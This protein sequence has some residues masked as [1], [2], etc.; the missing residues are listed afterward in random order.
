MKVAIGTIRV[1]HP[2]EFKHTDDENQKVNDTFWSLTT[3][4][5]DLVNASLPEGYYCKVEDA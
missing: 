3:Q 2:P 5:E 4:I 1:S